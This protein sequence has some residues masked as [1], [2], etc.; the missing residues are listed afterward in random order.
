MAFGYSGN[1]LGIIDSSIIVIGAVFLI[2]FAFLNY[3]L[4]KVFRDRYGNVNRA[5]AGII[6]FSMSVLIVYWGQ[7]TIYNLIQGLNIETGLLSILLGVIF[8]IGAIWVIS[9]LR[10]GGFLMVLGAGLIIVGFTDL[11]YRQWVVIIAGVVLLGIGIPLF[12]R[13]KKKKK[14]KE[15]NIKDSEEYKLLR[16]KNKNNF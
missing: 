15:L 9:K 6:A 8:V 7:N 4:S 1:L 14:L 13:W 10:F 16:R 12:L 5:T 3:T 2:F 11:V